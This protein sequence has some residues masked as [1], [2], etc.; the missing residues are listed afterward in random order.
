MEELKTIN[1]SHDDHNHKHD[2]HGHAHSD[3][4][5]K[6]I[7]NT[8][9]RSLDQLA[10]TQEYKDFLHREFPNNASELTDPVTRRNFM[11][12]M[13][14]SVALA[15]LSSCRMPKEAIVP[16]VKSPENV[17]PGRPKFYASTFSFAGH[18]HGV[19]VE[20]H[21]GRPTKIEGNELHPSSLGATH[22]WAL[23]SVLSLYDPDR[24]KSP[25]H[26]G[27]T[28][29]WSEFEDA[30]RAIA[31]TMAGNGGKGV[32]VLAE[33]FTSPTIEKLS[34]AFQKKYPNAAWVTYD[35]ISNEN[36][37]EGLKAVTG[38]NVQPVYHF[39]KAKIVVA[40]DSDFFST[41]SN[42][43]RY[44]KDFSKKRKVETPKDEMNRL[45][46]IE[47]SVTS[48][49][50]MADHRIAVSS[51]RIVHFLVALSKQLGISLPA[52]LSKL[53]FDDHADWIKALAN[54]LKKNRGASVLAT[55]SHQSPV[56][57][58]LAFLI[59]SQLG[60]VGT[61]VTTHAV[62][63]QNDSAG[64]KKLA[65]DMDKGQIN[66][67]IMLGGNP[68][69]SSP[70][71]LKF[72]DA[73]KKVENTIHASLYMDE[74]SL[75]SKWHLSLAHFLE[76]WSDSENVDGTLG[77]VQPLI[78]PLYDNKGM[79]EI[80]HLLTNNAPRSGYDIVAES[81]K[82]KDWKKTL[83][84]GVANGS[85]LVSTSASAANLGS[86]AVSDAGADQ[87]E[88]TFQTSPATFDGRFANN[89]WLQETPQ[90]ITK[91]TWDNPAL[92]SPAFA[93]EHGLKNGQFIELKKDDRSFE[94]PVWIVP[95]QAKNSITLFL[96]YGRKEGF[97]A[98]DKGFN[99]YQLRTT[100]NPTIETGFTV[101]KLSKT[102]LLACT[103]DHGSMEGRPLVREATMEHFKEH[104][105]FV[106]HMVEHPPLD[107][108]WKEHKYDEG[109][110]WGMV[111][112]LNSCTGCNA[113][114][115]S[116]QSENNIPIVGKEQVSKAREMQWLRI[117][118]YFNGSEDAPMIVHQPILCMHCENAPCEQVCPVNATVHDKEGLNVMTY[119]RCIG[120]RYCS[121]NC[122]YKVRRFNFFNYTKET[123][124]V[125][126]MAANPDVTIRFRGVMEKCTYC[127]QR[128]NQV[129]TTAKLEERKIR[130]GE[131]VTACQ[132]AC[133]AECIT[134]GDIND[135][136]SAVSKAKKRQHN[137]ALLQELN[138]KPRTTYL[139]K[140]RNPNPEI[141]GAA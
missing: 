88:V 82:G 11:K 24:S 50:A 138:I 141:K 20:S 68:V 86:L 45:Y 137:Y 85:N 75:A 105:D 4:P 15:G 92:I 98:K 72:A 23:A 67:L 93:K 46:S 31:K 101:S 96:G 124:Q 30:W 2:H 28:K 110:Q 134:F 107:S 58:A 42:S 65:Q 120:T 129:R 123:P 136:N 94:I 135:P 61:T 19:L 5:Q 76:S 78:E 37:V 59:N 130:D 111:I 115:I 87:I 1:H 121:N 16:Y 99:T 104:P 100:A 114:V 139:A 132:Q 22:G 26:E 103:Q 89:G 9:W 14:A 112:D 91:L 119:N 10:D 60:N 35:P 108:L 109:Y 18:T 74:T 12:I 43:V 44:T 122:P 51:S 8:Y 127:T 84:D 106:N 6:A 62:N 47:S 17:I 113:C 33:N 73:L 83:H 133:P 55:G 63:V 29:T 54:D 97:V 125:Q 69:Y 21:E 71:D 95:G 90:P 128:I 57:H 102:H 39:E 81:W 27:A 32:A 38:K 79:V 25:S 36:V 116:C 80:L 34:S 66:T 48:T 118:R 53:A 7:D 126:Q 64:L 49:G 52:S 40:V 70:V 77:I 3:A 41:E 13:G 117:D 56:V 131:I 140:L